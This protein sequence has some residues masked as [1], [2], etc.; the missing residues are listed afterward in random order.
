MSQKTCLQSC[1]ERSTEFL[2]EDGECEYWQKR[3]IA[4]LFCTVMAR[5]ILQIST[6]EQKRRIP[7]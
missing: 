6:P 3:A 4:V 5:F 7:P 1:F 2:E